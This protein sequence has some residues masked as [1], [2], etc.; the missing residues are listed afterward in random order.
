M[1]SYTFEKYY[2]FKDIIGAELQREVRTCSATPGE[3]PSKTLLDLWKEHKDDE[4]VFWPEH[5]AREI[6]TKYSE[7]Q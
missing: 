4:N 5:N 1:Q 3:L 6:L 7:S 2:A